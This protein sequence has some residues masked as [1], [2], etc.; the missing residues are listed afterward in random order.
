MLARAARLQLWAPAVGSPAGVV[1]ILQCCYR[2]IDAREREVCQL[3]HLHGEQSSELGPHMR[4]QLA[5]NVFEPAEELHVE[6]R[7]W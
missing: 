5:R 3:G 1:D 7:E 4:P 6:G 2:V